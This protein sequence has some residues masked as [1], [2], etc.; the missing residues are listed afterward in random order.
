MESNDDNMKH[1]PNV[2]SECGSMLSNGETYRTSSQAIGSIQKMFTESQLIGYVG[3][4]YIS[5]MD[6][7]KKNFID[8]PNKKLLKK[9]LNSYNEWADMI[10]KKLFTYLN[11]PP[12]HQKLI[13]SLAT[14][15]ILPEDLASPLITEAESAIE[16]RKEFEKKKREYIDNDFQKHHEKL[17]KINEG[18]ETIPEETAVNSENNVEESTI[19]NND[20]ED[21]VSEKKNE[22]EKV[23]FHSSHPAP[24]E[25][26]VRP[27]SPT[28]SSTISELS[29][30]RRRNDELQRKYNI[31][32][33]EM[34]EV[35][36]IRYI[37]LSHLFLL[38]I[39]DG[40]YD[41]R[42]RALLK[43]VANYLQVDDYNLIKIEK[44]IIFQI[45]SSQEEADELRRDET[46]IDNRASEYKKKRWLY[47]GL[48]SISG[49]I[50]IGLTAGL[51]APLIST[52]LGATLSM[53]HLGVHG[54]TAFLGSTGGIALISSAGT[55]TGA[56]LTGMKMAKRTRGVS[57]FEFIQIENWRRKYEEEKNKI[58]E[59]KNEEEEC[60]NDVEKEENKSEY[61]ENIK[62][63]EKDESEEIKEQI[64]DNKKEKKEEKEEIEEKDEKEEKD[65]EKSSVNNDSESKTLI[66]NNVDKK[67]EMEE[68][69]PKNHFINILITVSGWNT[70]IDNND[71]FLPWSVL[72]ENVYG[73]HYCLQWE[74]KELKE[75]GNAINIIASE[76]F[77]IGMKQLL[78]ATIL[79][80][81]A[82]M[83][84]PI[85]MMKLNYTVDNPWGIGLSKAQKTGLVL[86]D[87]LIGNYQE[88][89]PVTLIGYS[90]GARVIYYCL[91][92][93]A[94]K[95]MYGIVEDVYIIGTPVMES[96][97][98][99]EQCCSIVSGRFVNGYITHD[100]VLGFLYRASSGSFSTVAGLAPI[101]LDRIENVC[102]DEIVNG[103]LEYRRK[104]PLI[105]KKFGFIVTSDTFET[106]EESNEKERLSRE[107]GMKMEE[108]K[109]KM[110]KENEK[111]EMANSLHKTK[112]MSSDSGNGGFRRFGSWF[113][114]FA[115]QSPATQKHIKTQEEEL[116]EIERE[117]ALERE[118]LRKEIEEFCKPKEITSTLPK[119]VVNTNSNNNNSNQ[120]L[121]NEDEE[122]VITP[123]EIKST[124]PR[125]VVKLSRENIQNEINKNDDSDAVSF[126]MEA[127]ES[128]NSTEKE[129]YEVKKIPSNQPTLKIPEE[130]LID[131][132]QLPS[133]QPI[134]QVSMRQNRSESFSKRKKNV[135][136]V[137]TNL[138][139]EEDEASKEK[140]TAPSS[141]SY[142][143]ELYSQMNESAKI[144]DTNLL[145]DS[146]MEGD[147][148]DDD[149]EYQGNRS[150]ISS[151][152][153]EEKKYEVFERARKEREKQKDKEVIEK[154]KKFRKEHP[155][156][157]VTPVNENFGEEKTIT[158][159]ENNEN[160]NM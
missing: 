9:A 118:R 117:E 81:I 148:D 116:L 19:I 52:G 137:L 67:E 126:I 139:F 129:L 143:N 30:L 138:K 63:Q 76:L 53:I 29:E 115:P 55:L 101:P 31:S 82:A 84:L 79:P 26:T 122:P 159:V 65:D 89:R 134:L 40:M 23:D 60:K 155:I 112:S 142:L 2:A 71:F 58:E 147:D 14:H 22:Y 114:S 43:R 86:A 98:E 15:G 16:K 125:L 149:D 46:S 73:D 51:A 154:V 78:G 127:D 85:W 146:H 121:N 24:S 20:N 36:D 47:M 99:W 130:E 87:T 25:S 4:C 145:F 140:L 102:L 106:E 64:D 39:G 59:G 100:W 42:S 108:E 56:S 88:N 45:K 135:P 97:K 123:M 119:L 18:T 104:I 44:E 34:L 54:A 105:L 144:T 95:N 83:S 35:S 72:P 50:V 153:D 41:A 150:S 33:K 3:L 62:T 157:P 27:S 128:D 110:E 57:E 93:L 96:V 21:E 151:L 160:N 109:E 107:E 6:F 75:L 61:S 124:M 103:H 120:I 48:A 74:S 92:E 38:S 1:S 32:L 66:E 132:K 12:E 11:F 131:L 80:V 133:N 111:L 136:T 70:T 113:K 5:I 28:A 158:T 69:K 77:G 7:K 8:N 68:D 141:P 37:I 49:G 90:L 13:E 17:N 10:I 94:E 156:T 152:E 91:R